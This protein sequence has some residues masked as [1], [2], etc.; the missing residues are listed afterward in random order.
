M[1][2]IVVICVRN[3]KKNREYVLNVKILKEKKIM[4]VNVKVGIFKLGVL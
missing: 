2:R 3:V 4:I 1:I